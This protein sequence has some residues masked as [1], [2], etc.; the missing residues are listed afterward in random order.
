MTR[1]H[2]MAKPA[3]D[4]WRGRRALMA[5]GAALCAAVA[6]PGQTAVAAP[7]SSAPTPRPYAFTEDATTVKGATGT[8]G[9]EGLVPGRTY[10]SAV[11]KNAT[12][13]YG[14]EL[15]DT[16]DA[17]VSVTAVPRPGTTV[18]FSDG[19]K[20]SLRDGNGRSCSGSGIA[21]IGATQSPHPITASAAREI[22]SAGSALC[23]AAGT[24][25][26]VVERTGSPGGGDSGDWDLELRPSTEPRLK[27]AGTTSAPEVWNSASPD[28]LSGEGVACRGGAG[29]SNATALRQGIW[30]DGIS[31]GQTLFY[32]V[33]VDWGQQFYATADLGSSDS[34]GSGKGSVG[35]ALVMSLYNPVR[36]LVD[37]AGLGYYG[38][39]GSAALE[40]MPPVDYANRYALNDHVSG[41]R[42]AGS[43]YLVVHLAEQ[44]AERFGDGPFGLTLRVRV[45]GEAKDG[46]AYAGRTEPGDLFDATVVGPGPAARGPGG[47]GLTGG[48]SD[49][50]GGGS[51]MKLL[52]AGGIGTGTFLVLVLG[53]WTAIARR[54]VTPEPRPGG[55]GTASP[56]AHT[57]TAMPARRGHRAARRR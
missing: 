39:Q 5:A 54:R 48:T 46:P 27:K 28:P 51:T 56:T 30:T 41:M 38:R 35:T 55:L 1:A 12:L 10:K 17:Y 37:D 57:A 29:F 45:A 43:Y 25:Y 47:D 11:E 21:H 2:D 6:L 31:P 33:P 23:R 4:A 26:L 20:V 49:G 53:V 3:P 16:S 42:F 14:L 50:G 8:T 13:Y 7:A 19:V 36:G 34:S 40:P 18:A 9:A 15:D 24:Y 44:V 32:R 52:A 22:G